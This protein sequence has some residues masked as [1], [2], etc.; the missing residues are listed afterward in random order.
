M[1][2]LLGKEDCVSDF[3]YLGR[4]NAYTC[5]SQPSAVNG[6]TGLTEYEEGGDEQHVKNKNKFPSV[7]NG[8]NVN[9][10]EHEIQNNA[11]DERSRLDY[12]ISAGL[13]SSRC[14]GDENDPV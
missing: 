13:K 4:L 9:E 1:F 11:D 6:V 5:K 3:N 8:F 14:A 10:R 7:R 2:N 12:N